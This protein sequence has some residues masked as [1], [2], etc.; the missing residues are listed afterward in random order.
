MQSHAF[1]VRTSDEASC[2]TALHNSV[3]LLF[4]ISAKGEGKTFYFKIENNGSYSLYINSKLW[5]ESGP[6][7]FNALGETW[8]IGSTDNPLIP[9]NVRNVTGGSVVEQW[10]ETQFTYR[11]GNT[12]TSVMAAVRLYDGIYR[13]VLFTQVLHGPR[14]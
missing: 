5:L 11:L 14:L 6:T 9:S 10:Y 4:F 12:T 1:A 13:R 3:F 7:F 2:V 8:S